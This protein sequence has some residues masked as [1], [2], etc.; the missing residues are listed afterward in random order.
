MIIAIYSRK[1]KETD[2]GESIKNQIKMCENYFL[3]Q[4]EDCKFEIFQD[5]GFSGGN[6]DR[7]AFKRMMNLAKHK[8]FDIIAAY[9][10]DRISRNTLDFL[11]MFEE[12]KAN[13]ITLVSVT[14]GFDPS[15]PAGKMMM[16]MISSMAEMERENIRQRVKDNMLELAKIGRWS[17]GTTPTGYKSVTLVNDGKKSTYLELIEAEKPKLEFIYKRAAEG[18]TT[19]QIS[20]DIGLSPKTVHNIII[21]PVNLSATEKSSEYLK[22][23]GYNVLGE[24]NGY[25]FMPYNRR[26]RKNGKKLWKATD[27]LVSTGKHLTPISDDT[28]ITANI[29]ISNRGQE[30]KPRIS[31]SS[32][33]SHMVNCKCKGGMFIQPGR[34]NK[35]GER[36]FYFRCSSKKNKTNECDAKFLR[37]DDVEKNVLTTLKNISLDKKKLNEFINNNTKL[38]DYSK[39]I[40]AKKKLITN[41][42]KDIEILTEKLILIEGPAIK[43]ISTKINAISNEIDNINTEL[44]TLER[45]NILQSRNSINIDKLYNDILN[46]LDIFDTLPIEDK[47]IAIKQVIKGIDWDGENEISINILM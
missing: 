34:L 24:L 36:I 39:L 35:Y 32:F 42:N 38:I 10:I 37:V 47:Q 17:G 40:N 3:R 16:S 43:I 14:E 22:S 13:D 29:N 11:T 33:L 5:E 18:Y 15:T 19:F 30:A 12:L 44:L 46:L 6:T 41:K 45:A 31:P 8:Q 25:G 2:T 21:N 9:K 26:P 4:Y 20:K 28:W 1:S 7:P 27:M 23:I